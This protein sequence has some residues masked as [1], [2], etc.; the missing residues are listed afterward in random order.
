MIIF[1]RVSIRPDDDVMT[2]NI[3]GD[4]ELFVF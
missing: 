3:G 2:I 4:K 1:P